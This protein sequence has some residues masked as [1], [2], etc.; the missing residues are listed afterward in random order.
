[1][2]KILG[3]SLY[4]PLAASTRYRLEQYI[5]GLSEYDIDLQVHH[6]LGDQYLRSR[7]E[8]ARLPVAALLKAGY[9]RLSLLLRRQEF[10]ALIVHCELFPLMPGWLER[11]LLMKPYLYDFDDAFYL[12]YKTGNLSILRPL[13]SNKFD[14][15]IEGAAAVTAGNKELIAYAQKINRNSYV[16]PTVVDTDRYHHVDH[17]YDLTFTVG[18]IGSPSTSKYLSELVLP[19]SVLGNEG[20]IRLVVVGGA[21]PVVPNIEVIQE[22]WEEQKEIFHINSFD[23]GV[24]PLPDN[25][26]A[27]GKCAFKLIQYMACE[28]PVVASRVGT[29]IDVVQSDSGILVSNENEWI[30]AL[31][32]MRDQNR[33]RQQMGIAGR[34]RIIENYSLH[35]NVPLLATIIDN[36]IRKRENPS[37]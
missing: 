29:N 11:L 16:L 33:L 7:F 35:R 14:M 13:L 34:R 27:R 22:R 5:P 24:M 17:E 18:W 4:G 23:V 21:A 31:R 2:V 9:E 37:A 6:L 1:M 20:P 15:V 32:K 25:G 30:N 26:W 10:D 3:L 28:V 12:K 19:L 8:G 36:M